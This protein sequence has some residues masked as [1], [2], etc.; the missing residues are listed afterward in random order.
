MTETIDIRKVRI[1]DLDA[2]QKI[3]RDT[4]SETFA[5]MNKA[6]DMEKYLRINLSKEEL[7]RELL[8]GGQIGK[9]EQRDRA[10]TVV[11]RNVGIER[12][13]FRFRR[14]CLQPLA[15]LRGGRG[16]RPCIRGRF[17]EGTRGE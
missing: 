10:E 7:R 4:F 12:D 16:T 9:R 13:G 5:S 11:E 8:H 2:L 15:R 6:E 14:D 17:A 1:D 3:S